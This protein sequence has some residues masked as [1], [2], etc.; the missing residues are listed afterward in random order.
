MGNDVTK[1]FAKGDKLEENKTKRVVKI[2]P[3]KS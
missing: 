2:V 1:K 3:Q